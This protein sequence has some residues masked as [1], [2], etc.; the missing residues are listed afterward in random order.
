VTGD[1]L[2]VNGDW[3]MVNGENQKDKSFKMGNSLTQRRSQ[4][5]ES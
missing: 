3:L 2:M 1:W 5:V 4:I